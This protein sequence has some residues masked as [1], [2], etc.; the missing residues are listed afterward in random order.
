M[1][2]KW[3]GLS[4]D[5]KTVILKHLDHCRPNFPEYFTANWQ[6]K[7]QDLIRRGL[8]VDIETTGLHPKE[9]KLI[10]LG[11]RPFLFNRQT[12]EILKIEEGFSGLEDPGFPISDEIIQITGITNEMIDDK[13]IDWKLAETIFQDAA[14]II[15]HNARFDRPFVDKLVP[16]SSGKI[17]ACSLSQIDWKKKGF[18]SQKLE[19]L[20]IYHG[21]FN[22]AHRA[23]NDVNS[24]LY[25]L[26]IKDVESKSPYLLELI[27][28]ARRS[29]HQIVAHSTPYDKKDNLKSRQYRWDNS[30]RFWTKT[31]Y[32][33]DLKS[34]IDWLEKEIYSGPFGG[35]VRDLSLTDTF[36][37]DNP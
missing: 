14:L 15:A 29:M 21:F 22:D 24:L 2:Q 16:S 27:Q 37:I 35:L 33:E 6:N 28:N 1:K 3:H 17:W 20:T 18:L 30:N 32:A 8:V 23:L 10:E 13:K 36:K 4:E 19:L 31:I 9:D 12:G 25:L 11:L 7:N 26:S 5:G 34:E